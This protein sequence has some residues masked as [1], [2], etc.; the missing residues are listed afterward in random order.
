LGSGRKKR[1]TKKERVKER[2]IRERGNM[3]RL[4]GS[5]KVYIYER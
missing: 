1:G 2:K 4:E 3:E 5:K